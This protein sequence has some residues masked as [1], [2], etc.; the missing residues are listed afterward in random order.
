MACCFDA[1]LLLGRDGVRDTDLLDEEDEI[2]RN[3]AETGLAK[4][5]VLR[6]G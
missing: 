3:E 4:E 2:G 5:D 1:P 6:E